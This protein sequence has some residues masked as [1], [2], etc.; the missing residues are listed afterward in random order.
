MEKKR[1]EREGANNPWVM[2]NERLYIA[3]KHGFLSL[4]VKQRTF[5]PIQITVLSKDIRQLVDD[6]AYNGEGHLVFLVSAALFYRCL[7]AFPHRSTG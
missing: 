4:A 2:P 1:N 3:S 7:H 5:C 6:L